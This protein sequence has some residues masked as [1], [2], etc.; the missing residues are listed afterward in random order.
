MFVNMCTFLCYYIKHTILYS[1]DMVHLTFERRQEVGNNAVRIPRKTFFGWAC[2]HTFNLL[3]LFFVCCCR[4][5]K[6]D[7]NNC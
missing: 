6:D 5:Q 3:L 7:A 1:L 2:L 4:L